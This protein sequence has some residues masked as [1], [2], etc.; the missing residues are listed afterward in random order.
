MANTTLNHLVFDT[1]NLLRAGVT[2]DDDSLD[3]RQIAF[4][5]KNIRAQLIRQD[6]NKN[7]S[8]SDNIEQHLDCID[9]E[10]VDASVT[11][12]INV[13]CKV[14]RSTLQIPK[15]IEIAQE[16]LITEIG[17]IAI[18]QRPFHIVPIERIPYI[19]FTPFAGINNSIKA[20]I[21][22]RYVYIFVPKND[23]VIKKISLSG[24]FADPTDAARFCSCSGVACYT[25]DSPYPISEHMIEIG[26][27]MIID[28]NIRTF[29]T[30][31]TDTRG[32]ANSTVQPNSTKE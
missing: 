1:A 6:L 17:P 25:D 16:D 29:L 10:Q 2:S 7:R 22:D 28:T 8:I 14:Y 27:K 3:L 30:V 15:P 21:L 4:W 24:V 5:W 9:V 26:K 20:A 13:D 32:D 19:G 23:R 12:G 11:C 31:G 18:G